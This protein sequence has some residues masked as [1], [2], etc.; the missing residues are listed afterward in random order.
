MCVFVCKGSRTWRVGQR[1]NQLTKRSRWEKEL[2]RGHRVLIVP[3]RGI[4]E[5]RGQLSLSVY[6]MPGNR[7]SKYMIVFTPHDGLRDL[8]WLKI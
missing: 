5:R 3:T 7:S 2:N 4:K 8:K 6:C 1:S